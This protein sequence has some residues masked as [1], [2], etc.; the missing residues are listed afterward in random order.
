MSFK[1]YMQQR[2][3]TKMYN[4]SRKIEQNKIQD[5]MEVLRLS[6]SSINSQP[7]KFTFVSDAETKQQLSKVSWLNTE[8]VLDS[9]TVVVFSRIN[10][11]DLFE[12][13]IEAELP[14]RAVD[15]YKEFIKPMPEDQIKSWFNR[16]L[17]LSLGV[18]LSACAAMGIDATPMEGIEPEQYDRILN[19][20]DYAAVVAVAIGYRDEDDFNQPSK[21]PKSRRD[22]EKVIETV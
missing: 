14:G 2:Y 11:L 4:P 15:Y 20:L 7:W 17:Y 12:Q 10:S 21:R 6:P 18:F 5:L 3:T 9:D 1:E 16:Q 22:L 19:Q 13:Q 8:K